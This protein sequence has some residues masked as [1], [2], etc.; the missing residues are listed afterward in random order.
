MSLT[1]E[2]SNG[3]LGNQQIFGHV[4]EAGGKKAEFS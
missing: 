3:L 1:T 4:H 2:L